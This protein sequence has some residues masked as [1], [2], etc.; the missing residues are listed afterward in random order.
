M[1]YRVKHLASAKSLEELRK[2]LENYIPWLYDFVPIEGIEN[3]WRLRYQKSG[4][5]M[6]GFLVRLAGEEPHQ[7]YRLEYE[8]FEESL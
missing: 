1:S 3:Q 4:V 6:E 8:I 2:P 7:Y 5:D